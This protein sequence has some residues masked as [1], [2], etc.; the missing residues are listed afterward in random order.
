[1]SKTSKY[2]LLAAMICAVALCAVSAF[3]YL[4]ARRELSELKSD[5]SASNAA[6]TAIDENKQSVLTDLKRAKNE[7]RDA[8]LI[9][10][11]AG[12]KT[13]ELEKDI[14]MLEKDI[15]ALSSPVP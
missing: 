6:W 10:Q 5:L 2:L 7:L 4:N 1:M 8:D 12:E 14:E 3:Q 9:I 11:E 15:E 13:E